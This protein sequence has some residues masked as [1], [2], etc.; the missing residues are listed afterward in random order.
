MKMALGYLFSS[1]QFLGACD[2][3]PEDFLWLVLFRCAVSLEDFL[4]TFEVTFCAFSTMKDFR[5][6]FP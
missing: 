3:L 4:G 1:R 2:N 6:R 5:C